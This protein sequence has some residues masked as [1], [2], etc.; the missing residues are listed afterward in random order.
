M[1]I[2]WIVN[3]SSVDSESDCGGDSDGESEGVESE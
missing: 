3:S 1:I 2:W